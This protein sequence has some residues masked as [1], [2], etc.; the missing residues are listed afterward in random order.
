MKPPSR[1]AGAAAP[2]QNRYQF[3]KKVKPAGLSFDALL[4]RFMTCEKKTMSDEVTRM[5]ASSRR[6]SNNL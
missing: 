3:K 4:E 1:D 6:L 5:T 2:P